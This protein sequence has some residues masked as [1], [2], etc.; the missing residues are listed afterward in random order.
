MR[1]LYGIKIK[2]ISALLIGL[3]LLTYI[4]VSAEPTSFEFNLTSA[5]CGKNAV[6]STIGTAVLTASA[7]GKSAEEI[8]WDSDPEHLFPRMQ[9]KKLTS[10]WGE[11]GYWLIEFSSLNMQNMKFSA[12]MYSSGKGPGDFELLYS[13]DNI[14]FTKI[15][16]SEVSLSQNPSK[17]YSEFS[18]PEE[19]ENQPKVYLKIRICS[20]LSVKGNPITGVKDGSTYINYISVS[21]QDSAEPGKPDNPPTDDSEKKYYTPSLNIEMNRIGKETGKY[22]FTLK[23][24]K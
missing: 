10:S 6:S 9:G 17:V 8:R 5:D 1:Y 7:D 14:T 22:K 19:M 18:L 21:S 16:N 3:L 2:K 24:Q 23:L 15:T 20:D 4:T 12:V 11:G 13:D